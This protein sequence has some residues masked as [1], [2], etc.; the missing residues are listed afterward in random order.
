MKL[1]TTPVPSQS[2]AVYKIISACDTAN[3]KEIAIQ[4]Q[5]LPNTIY[6]AVR[7]LL[8]L[9]LIEKLSTYPVSFKV[10]PNDLAMNWYVRNAAIDYRQIFGGTVAVSS[11]DTLPRLSIIKD[12]KALLAICEKEAQIAKKTIDY[13]VSG[14]SVPNS[15]I[16]AY[17]KASINGVRIRTIVQN[18]PATTNKRGVEM[19]DDIGAEVRY[20]PNIG[21]RLF[22]FDSKT[23]VLVSYDITR[24]S[25][26]FGIKFTYAPAAKQLETLFEQRWLQASPINH[27]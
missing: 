16:L 15:T 7:P 19:Y 13:I 1:S 12:R 9:N 17:R 26:A 6:R 18:D 20:L 4:L 21:I 2:L 11:D 25:S 27:T 14:H 8:K 10:L 3:A 5:V 22:V 23:A 24:Q